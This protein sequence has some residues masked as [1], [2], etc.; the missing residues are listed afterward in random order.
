MQMQPLFTA[1]KSNKRSMIYLFICDHSQTEFLHP[2][3]LLLPRGSP[4]RL[5]RADV[6]KEE[7]AGGLLPQAEEED[8][9]EPDHGEAD[10]AAHRRVLRAA[11]NWKII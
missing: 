9:G 6:R 10:L 2:F 11:G 7:A 4:G 8:Y 1:W 3:N 5:W